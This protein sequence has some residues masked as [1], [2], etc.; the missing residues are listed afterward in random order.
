MYDL[1]LVS[2]GLA[3][4]GYSPDFCLLYVETKA[5]IKL[6]CLAKE[7]LKLGW[8]FV[9]RSVVSCESHCDCLSLG[10]GCPEPIYQRVGLYMIVGV[11]FLDTLIPVVRDFIRYLLKRWIQL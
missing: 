3:L 5:V 8:F 6:T 9:G 11:R 7:A 10:E 1:L 2:L 4:G